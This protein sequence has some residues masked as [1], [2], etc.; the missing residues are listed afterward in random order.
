MPIHAYENPEKYSRHNNLQ[1]QFAKDLLNKV[2]IYPTD[3]I[4][5]IGCGDGRITAELALLANKASVM[6]TDISQQMVDHANKTYKKCENLSFIRMDASRNI[7]FNQFNV[8]TSF[9]CLHWVK[10]QKIALQGIAASA[11]EGARIV[12]LLSHKKS[13]YHHA[14]D[15]ICENVKWSSYFKDYETPRLFFS[16]DIYRNFLE[17]IGLNV[18]MFGEEEMTHIYESAEQLKSF[19]N[20]SMAQ[21]KQIPP[22]LQDEFLDDLTDELIKMLS[23]KKNDVIPVSFWCLQIVAK[24]PIF[25]TKS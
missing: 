24:K 1:Y 19:F 16:P 21:L 22:H 8:V 10:D 25:S 4:L 6:G 9:N 15:V 14:L 20:A 18:I 23:V 13:I 3:Q 7:F 5:D 12:L 17:E 11:V 2:E